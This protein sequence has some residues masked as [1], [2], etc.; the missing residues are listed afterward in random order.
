[1]PSESLASPQQYTFWQLGLISLVSFVP[2]LLLQIF[3][4]QRLEW[5][6]RL[7]LGL[8]AVFPMAVLFFRL[9]MRE[10]KAYEQHSMSR[11]NFF[12]LPWGL[13]FRKYGLRLLGVSIAW[14]A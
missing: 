6:W 13:I 3:T 9:Q 12:K 4:E 14:A 2:Y 8:G 7:T 1:M 5:V 11:I 10:P